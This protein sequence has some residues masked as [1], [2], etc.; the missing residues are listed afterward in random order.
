VGNTYRENTSTARFIPLTE[1]T[2]PSIVDVNIESA[3]GHFDRSS[4][5]AKRKQVQGMKYERKS[6]PIRDVLKDRTDFGE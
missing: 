3:S 4:R 6:V 5:L 1:R 2:K